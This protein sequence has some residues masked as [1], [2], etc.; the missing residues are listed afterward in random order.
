MSD[1]ICI[2]RLRVKARLG[3][4]AEERSEPQEVAVSVEMAPGGGVRHLRDEIEGTV[5]YHEVARGIGRVCA[6][7]PRKLLETLAEDL[8]GFL[9]R[10]YP[11]AAAAVE[12]E[13]F[14]LPDAEA[15]S[16]K[17]SSAAADRVARGQGG[18]DREGRGG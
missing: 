17:V 13:K 1:V 15:V 18:V 3:V 9:L 12:V 7:R 10:E 14:I 16:V 4:T 8:L 5:D 2:K 6:E 11:L